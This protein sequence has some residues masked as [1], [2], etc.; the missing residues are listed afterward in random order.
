MQTECTVGLS[1]HFR[2]FFYTCNMRIQSESTWYF[3]ILILLSEICNFPPPLPTVFNPRRRC[4]AAKRQDNTV[5]LKCFDHV[6][7]SDRRFLAT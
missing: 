6:F 3:L 2:L 5:G 1:V 4:S 7:V